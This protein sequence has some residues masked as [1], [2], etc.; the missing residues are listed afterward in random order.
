[1]RKGVRCVRLSCG[2][3]LTYFVYTVDRTVWD[4]RLLIRP[5]SNH[6]AEGCCM[7]RAYGLCA[8][9]L[10]FV[11][12]PAHLILLIVFLFSSVFCLFFFVEAHA[13]LAPLVLP[14]TGILFHNAASTMCL[15][16]PKAVYIVTE[17]D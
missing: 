6:A 17:R 12:R 1:M 11:L 16:A 2:I 14:P 10:L 7:K 5:R 15:D 4:L 9:A 8:V 13:H 3:I